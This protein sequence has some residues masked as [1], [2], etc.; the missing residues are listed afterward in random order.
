[1]NFRFW[2]E[3]E[4]DYD[5][6]QDRLE[7]RMF[8]FV[9][10]KIEQAAKIASDG[11]TKLQDAVARVWPE[12]E[13][14]RNF[15][16]PKAEFPDHSGIRF[17]VEPFASDS[18]TVKT[19]GVVNTISIGVKELHESLLKGDADAARQHLN[20]IAGS[21]NHEITHL[22]H[23]GADEGD[24]GADDAIRYL[25]NPGEMRAH[26]KDYAYTWS[27]MFPGQPFDAQKFVQAVIPK[28]VQSKQRK[29][30][31]YFVA[32]ADPA[33]QAKYKHV[34]DVENAYKRLIGMVSGYVDYYTKNAGGGTSTPTQTQQTAQK[35]QQ[36]F[37]GFQLGDPRGAKE[38]QQ[39]LN[40]IGINTD[41][42]G[43]AE[44]M[45]GRRNKWNLPSNG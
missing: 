27:R 44:I 40:S 11:S 6:E 20:R 16:L 18:E 15:F 34:A 45:Q 3:Q 12:N 36:A 13:R 33:K 23:K 28:L 24:G 31:N 39:H 32:F 17:R 8:Q 5:S 21:L 41:G 14:G 22:H 42:W 7:H 10:G 19:N 37:Q 29:A 30:N 35:P 38:R 9:F 1:M 25:T 4:H 43:R 26:A 2:L